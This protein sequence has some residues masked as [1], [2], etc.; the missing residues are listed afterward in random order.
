[1]KIDTTTAIT[2]FDGTIILKG[3]LS[4]E[5]LNNF[6]TQFE[7]SI[8]KE[9]LVNFVNT[10]YEKLT[11]KDIITISLQNQLPNEELISEKEKLSRFNLIEDVYKNKNV[12]LTNEQVRLI[13]EQVNKFYNVLVYGRVCEALNETH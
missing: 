1:M 6:I 13:K 9:D 10:S 5:T 12:D 3:T 7:T 4:V 8:P 11:L 2:N